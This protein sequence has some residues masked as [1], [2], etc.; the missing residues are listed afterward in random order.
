MRI[1]QVDQNTPEWL[2]A[3]KGKITGSKLKDIVV[4][5]GNGKK[6][7]FYQLIAD[8]LAIDEAPI[9]PRQRGHSLEHEALEMFEQQTGTQVNKDV[10]ICVSDINEA[11]AISPDG[12]IA[13]EDGVYRS[14]VEVKCLGSARHIEA[15]LTDELPDEYQFQALQYFIVIDEL[16]V[17]YFTM[18][19]PRV[20]AKP[21]HIIQ[22][23]REDYEADIELYRDYQV[24]TLQE[25]DAA[26]TKL[27][28]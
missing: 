28:F 10:G 6:I 12:L 2:E 17:L 1:I 18:Y 20:V 21:L 11:I 24:K 13:D 5:R 27:A 15:V 14:A 7:G 4:K 9:D 25:V 22:L 23:A 8:R 16:E 26:L 19:D 3:R